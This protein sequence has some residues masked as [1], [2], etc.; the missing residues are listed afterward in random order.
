MKTATNLLLFGQ[1]RISGLLFGLRL[2]LFVFPGL[3]L[4]QD[5]IV[6]LET[7]P[8]VEV[9]FAAP[10]DP[11]ALR[12]AWD[13]C[14]GDLQLNPTAQRITDFINDPNTSGNDASR[15]EGLEIVYDDV[16]QEWF[17]FITNVSSPTI[18][19]IEFGNHLNNPN[20]NYFRVPVGLTN[21]FEMRFRK[22]NDNWYAISTKNNTSLIRLNFGSSLRNIPTTQ[23]LNNPFS[24]NNFN[25]I[26]LR[27]YFANIFALD[28]KEDDG[29][30][31]AATVNLL[32]NDV[33][34]TLV[35]FGSSVSN[36]YL[37]TD[38]I[39]TPFNIGTNIQGISIIKDVDNWY[40]IAVGQGNIVHLDFGEDLFSIPT[41]TNLVPNISGF[42]ASL[43]LRRITLVK[44]GN[45]FSVIA[46]A[47]QGNIIR[48]NFGNSMD[49]V[50]Q[51]TQ[52]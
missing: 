47:S 44:E 11:E 13:F 49:N 39:Q 7:C 17:G 30:V 26:P 37:D 4:A 19:R 28:L 46:N 21:L 14:T 40:G 48:L 2:G 16:N 9:P 43:D 36:N 10:A 34:L 32:S 15:P 6:P 1:F 12:Y 38:A 8:Q 42:N 18:L 45:N 23:Y 24:G 5:L 27:G 20:P 52:I 33:R 50:F 22:E 29:N 35:N 25:Q 3:A 31:I 51:F 41:V